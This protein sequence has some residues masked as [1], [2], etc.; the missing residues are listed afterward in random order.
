MVIGAPGGA[1]QEKFS[2]QDGG[3]EKE[4]I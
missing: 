3:Y 1:G 2:N 4:L